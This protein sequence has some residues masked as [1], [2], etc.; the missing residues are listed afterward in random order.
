[1]RLLAPANELLS[2]DGFW[3]HAGIGGIAAFAAPGFWRLL[4]FR[5]PMPEQVVVGDRFYL[6][7]LFEAPTADA[8]FAVLAI[9]KSERRLYLG[10]ASGLEEVE[11]KAPTSLPDE[12]RFDQREESLQFQSFQT[13]SSVTGAERGSAAYHGQGGAKDRSKED[14]GRYLQDIENEVT[15]IL[16]RNGSPPLVLAGVAYE[17]ASY[18]DLNRYRNTLDESIDSNP[19]R[20]SEA[21]LRERALALL[22]PVFAE[23]ARQALDELDEKLGTGLASNDITEIL[24]AAAAGR[25]KALLFDD[26]V[27]PFGHFDA[28]SLTTEVVGPE[29]PRMLR[30]NRPAEQPAGDGSGWDLVDL[31]AAE[32]CTHAGDVFAFWGE[33]AP[34]HGVAAVFRY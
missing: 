17:M 3:R 19:D 8:P 16:M 15:D 32:T 25:V 10:N 9:S 20:L 7:P 5:A 12:L 34:V 23:P 4:R 14:L 1:M 26:S 2:D 31:A 30:A 18:R 24:P 21:D 22:R 27:G 33:D 28:A 6:R 13:P 11:L 29:M